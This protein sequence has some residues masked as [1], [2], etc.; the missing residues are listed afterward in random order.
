MPRQDLPHFHAK[1][2]F[3]HGILQYW[4]G[5]V[6]VKVDGTE[7]TYVGQRDIEEDAIQ[8]ASRRAILNL[9][10]KYDDTFDESI[11]RLIP[12]ELNDGNSVGV[13]FPPFVNDG[14]EIE[15]VREIAFAAGQYGKIRKEYQEAQGEIVQLRGENI[16]LRQNILDLETKLKEAISAQQKMASPSA[17]RLRACQGDQSHGPGAKK[18]K[19]IWT[20]KYLERFKSAPQVRPEEI[21]APPSQED[22]EEEEPMEREFYT[23]SNPS[24]DDE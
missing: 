14:S 17:R 1:A 2:I 10:H 19:T 5:W 6:N 15:V 23:S 24:S 11:Y 4:T 3:V 7:T 8:D 20:K 9:R 22:E 13:P 21:E 18:I 16:E 12:Q